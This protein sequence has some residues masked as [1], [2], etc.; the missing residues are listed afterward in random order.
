MPSF[1]YKDVGRKALQWQE[2]EQRYQCGMVVEPEKYL[3]KFPK[4]LSP[5][6]SKWCAARIAMDI[7]CD[8]GVEF[9]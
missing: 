6:I 9:K 1:F 4:C 8:S 5:L 2:A 7:G 3:R